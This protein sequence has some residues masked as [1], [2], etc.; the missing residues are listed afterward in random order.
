MNIFKQQ[1]DELEHSHRYLKTTD[2]ENELILGE[3]SASLISC[4]EDRTLFS[5]LRDSVHEH[6]S[7]NT[8]F[9]QHMADSIAE[10]LWRKSRY[11]MVECTALS[12][13]IERDWDAVKKECPNADPAYRT[14]AAFRDMGPRDIASL[15]ATQ[16]YEARA[17]RR[18]R[19]DI[20]VL[21]ALRSKA[22]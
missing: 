1:S 11:S 7:P 5:N 12:A 16:D 4:V 17:W 14:Y 21:S 3:D 9:E 20:S 2:A 18:S 10:E 19:S 13:S 6:F 22:R 15:R 8:R